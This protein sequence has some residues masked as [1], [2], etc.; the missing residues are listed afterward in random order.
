[1]S[2]TFSRQIKTILTTQLPGEEAHNRVMPTGRPRTSEAKTSSIEY[3]DSA[4]GIFIFRD[5]STFKSLLIQRPVYEGTHGGQVSFPGGKAEI[6]DEN[7]EHTAR[8]ESFEEVGIPLGQGELLGK[9]T[10]VYIPVSKFRVQPYVFYLE[11]LPVLTPDAYEV[12]GIISF[13]L[14]IFKS[15]EIKRKSIPI[16]KGT[17]LKNMA[18]FD[19]ENKVVWGATALMLSELQEV[20]RLIKE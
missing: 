6:E 5:N 16:A 12:D 9:L 3:R 18:Y 17:I 19:I 13:D 2:D 14:A 10:D 7:L 11:D 8:R 15:M 1:M 20:L 4:V